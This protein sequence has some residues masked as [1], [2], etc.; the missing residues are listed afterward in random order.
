MARLLI[1]GTLAYDDIGYFDAPL[2]A[3]TR[4]VKLESLHR[5]FGGCAMNIAYNLAGLGHLSVPFVYAGDDYSAGYAH[6]VAS[7]GISE[8]GIYRVPGTPSARGIVLTGADGV[9]FTAFYPGPSGTERWQRDL[10]E[11]HSGEPFDAVII[12]P[13]LAGKMVGCAARA[14]RSALRI[15]CPGQYAELLERAEIEPVLEHC[16]LLVVN[17][18]EWQALAD[19]VGESR[20]RQRAQ[21]TVITD[22]AGPVEVLPGTATGTGRA[23]TVPVPAVAATDP[24]GCGDAFVAALADALLH[25]AELP[26]AAAA[27]IRLAARCLQCRGAQSHRVAD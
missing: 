10:E 4:N 5:D 22:G 12:A 16:N 17:R 13:D 27:G 18:H 19:R 21:P 23:A 14:R 7:H 6:H 20:L 3:G 1:C 24:T 9:Q 26:S 25:G 15:W 2:H 8:A 11:L